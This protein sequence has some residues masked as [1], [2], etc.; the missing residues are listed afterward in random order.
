MLTS[1]SQ[2]APP[3]RPKYQPAS[4]EETSGAGAEGAG[5]PPKVEP[6]TMRRQDVKTAAIFMA[7]MFE[8]LVVVCD[9]KTRGP[10][11]LFQAHDEVTLHL[12]GTREPP[13]SD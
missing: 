9:N 7:W 11:I 10:P 13:T 3:L 2:S 6:V 12:C 1:S 8:W 5:V 4:E